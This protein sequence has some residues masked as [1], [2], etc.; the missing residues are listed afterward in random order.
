M[1][2]KLKQKQFRSLMLLATTIAVCFIFHQAT[3][4]EDSDGIVD[5]AEY[6][7]H[8]TDDR[9][10]EEKTGN[11]AD[12]NWNVCMKLKVDSFWDFFCLL[13]FD[14]LVT[15]WRDPW[16]FSPHAVRNALSASRSSI[17]LWDCQVHLE[18]SYHKRL[19]PFFQRYI[20]HWILT[21]SFDDE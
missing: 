9:Y 6:K 7:L 18:K 19:S 11:A 17:F 12:W 21:Y 2:W 4:L 15:Y 8:R 5:C 1:N 20:N 14:K 3:I 16:K 10:S 13:C